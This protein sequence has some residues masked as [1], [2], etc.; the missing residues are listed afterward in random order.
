MNR[1]RRKIIANIF[2]DAAK[3]VL[4]AGVIGGFISGSFSL[5]S[6]V[7]LALVFIILSLAA[8]FVTPKDKED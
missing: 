8:Y 4:T 5:Y 2:G 3:Y 1:D 6:G 7:P